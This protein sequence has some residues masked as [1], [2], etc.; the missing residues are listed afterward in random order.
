MSTLYDKPEDIL[1]FRM[2]SQK[3]SLELEIKGLRKKGRTMYSMIKQEY[4]LKGSRES[5]L[6]Q[7]G[8]F[9]KENRL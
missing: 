3:A 9:I 5:V 1:L 7:F 6:E 2:L 8:N 4:N